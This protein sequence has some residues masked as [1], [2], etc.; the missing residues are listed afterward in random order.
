MQLYAN[1]ATTA[2]IAA[3]IED[4]DF[5]VLV[6]TILG[7]T[8]AAIPGMHLLTSSVLTGSANAFL[9]LRVGMITKEYCRCTIRVERSKIRRAATVQAA[10]LLG[11]IVKEGTVRL[12]KA[13]ATGA[14]ERTVRLSKA[15]ATGAK[16]G[17]V[18]LTKAVATGTKTK[19]AE[20]LKR[21]GSFRR[22]PKPEQAG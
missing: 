8:V 17:T 14:K 11:N 9:T 10:K 22:T 18:R 3:G 7:T 4:V 20:T 2:F 16:E 12:S 19:I 21:I 6:S 15:V 13:V 1:V 5:D